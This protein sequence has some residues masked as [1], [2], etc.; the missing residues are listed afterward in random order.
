MAA[1]HTILSSSARGSTEVVATGGEWPQALLAGA[2]TDLLSW[3][4][5][6][7]LILRHAA[8]GEGP[9]LG[10]ASINLD[11]IHH[12]GG[13]GPW[14]G[15]L[16]PTLLDPDAATADLAW[17]KLLDGRPLVTRA[18]AL[19]RQ[20]WP[21]LA[22]SDLIAPLLDEAGVR[23]LR[24]GFLGG[25]PDVQ[26]QLR[27]RLAQE[28]PLLQTVG[29]W[30]P[31]RH[32]LTDRAAS[33]RIAADVRD[34]GVDMLVVAL[35]KPRQELW[36]HEFGPATGARVLLAFGA[37][38][39]FLAGRVRRAPA[40]TSELG[41]E[42]A[43]RLA[44][45]PRRLY[46]RYLMQ[47]PPGYVDLR[48]SRL[49]ASPLEVV[50]PRATARPQPG[51]EQ[52]DLPAAGH[53]DELGPGAWRAPLPHAPVHTFVLAGPAVDVAVL[54]VTHNS[55]AD[56]GRLLAS[57]RRQRAGMRVVVVDNASTD[58]T[59]EELASQTDVVTVASEQ[60]LG[61]AGGIN[62]ATAAAGPAASY[63]VLNPDLVL[64][65]N[66]V[67]AM[68]ERLQGYGVGAVVPHFVENGSTYRS[69]RREPTPLRALGEALFGRRLAGRP[70]WLSEMVHEPEAYLHPHPV[71]WATGAAILVDAEVARRVG[72]WNESFF[73]YS[74][75]TDFCRRV[76]AVGSSI[77]Y[78]PGAKVS[79]RIGGSGQS[80]L[81]TALM[82]VNRLRYARLHNGRFEA[83]V[84]MPAVLLGS[85][86]RL[87]DPGRREAA[88]ALVSRRRRRS[89]SPALR[90]GTR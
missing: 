28:K 82:E 67:T 27:D 10:V 55:R 73:L 31:E 38:V 45:E 78:E 3:Q 34:R 89:L 13:R 87:R 48:R 59:L 2:V 68:L 49:H 37:A 72:P 33:N 26:A 79:H 5:A 4:H 50:P 36:I 74:E 39:D 53:A 58:G 88:L 12:F 11:H 42:W 20:A 29:W 64:D 6:V 81:L 77:W 24:V 44:L 23:G 8:P 90:G 57:L 63:L 66:A 18:S 43:W 35:G 41:L 25:R 40:W 16:V 83:A 46:R 61:Y 84:M 47:G 9:P 75:E 52:L 86:L 7:D 22:G 54:V 19:T 30:A 15:T 70:R 21:R 71:D 69:L 60:N 32:D 51:Y 85:V 65:D 76:R 1:P 17:L 80:P 62:L 14:Q 56:V